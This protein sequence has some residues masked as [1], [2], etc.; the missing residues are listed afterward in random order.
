M[1]KARCAAVDATSARPIRRVGRVRDR[2]AD[3]RSG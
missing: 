1:P 3:I 2:A